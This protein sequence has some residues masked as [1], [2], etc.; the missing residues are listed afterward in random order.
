MKKEFK[1][2][3]TIIIVLGIIASVFYIQILLESLSWSALL[4][5]L[6]W[7]SHL[8]QSVIDCTCLYE[9][10]A[11]EKEHPEWKNLSTK[12]VEIP[13]GRNS[14][15]KWD[16][17]PIFHHCNCWILHVLSSSSDNRRRNWS[18]QN[19]SRDSVLF[20]RFDR[21]KN[22]TR[23]P[24]WLRKMFKLYKN[25]RKRSDPMPHQIQIH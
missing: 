17:D 5:N 12:G 18:D 1:I 14:K 24:I 20:Q 10:K 19:L 8:H 25:W 11:A 22:L 3:F 21:K 13:Q 23:S 9:K 16:I 7:N 6:S 4:Y 15:T 2:R